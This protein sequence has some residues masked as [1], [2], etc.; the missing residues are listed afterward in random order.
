MEAGSQKDNLNNNPSEN[1]PPCNGR[2]GSVC[3]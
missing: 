2:E 1:D 3:L